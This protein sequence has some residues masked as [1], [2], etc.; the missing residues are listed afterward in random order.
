MARIHKATQAICDKHGLELAVQLEGG[1][2]EFSLDNPYIAPFARHITDVTGITVEGSYTL[3][4]S[5][6]RHFSDVG[7]PCVSLYPAGAGHHGPEE[8]LSEE[9]FYQFKEV[10]DRYMDEV[11]KVSTGAPSLAAK[12]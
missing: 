4:S 2:V 9:A 10:L 11:A 5:D 3:G 6:A 7:V 1:P 12:H 8:W